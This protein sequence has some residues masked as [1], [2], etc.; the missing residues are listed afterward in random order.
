MFSLKS[1]KNFIY[2]NTVLISLSLFEYFLSLPT[3]NN[4][5]NFSLI[6][7]RNYFLIDLLDN[8]LVNKDWIDKKNRQKPI[9]YFYHEFDLYVLSSSLIETLS[10]NVINK[11][12]LSNSSITMYDFIYFIPTSFVFELI[13]DF[14]HYITHRLMH[15]KYI[16]QYLHKSHH[17]F[18]YPTSITTF[19]QHP[20]DLIITNTFPTIISL[21][22][23]NYFNE[24][25]MSLFMFKML[26]VYLKFVEIS[27]HAGKY[28]K[29][30][31]FPQFFWIPKIL[32]I[33]LTTEDHDLHHSLNNCN[34]SKR[35]SLWDKLFLTYK[36]H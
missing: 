26:S 21:L 5:I 29:G 19:Y 7:M 34:Y 4:Y 20:I 14:F 8:S 23:I 16:Y 12:C 24:E 9:E 27:G 35:F 11:Y 18:K 3:Y 10:F 36:K 32:G 31:S 33:K 28:F 17:K 2:I 15:N 30:S 6:I 22:I 25:K 13:F 1:I